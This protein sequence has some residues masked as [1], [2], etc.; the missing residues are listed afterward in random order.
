MSSRSGGTMRHTKNVKE[1]RPVP[2]WTI[3]AAVAIAHLAIALPALNPA[4]HNGGD[5]AGYIS[6]AHSLAT[7]ESYVEAW[8]PAELPH[9][10]YPPFYPALLA[11]AMLLG[12][13]AW[14]T[15]KLL[16]VLLIT[17]AVVLSFG[18]VRDRHGSGL[19]TGV[20]AILA[21]S[22]AL[23]WSSNWILSDPLFLALTLGCL[24]AFHRSDDVESASRTGH[25]PPNADPAG[26]G[27]GAGDRVGDRPG[28]RVGGRAGGR[29]G[30]WI[31]AGCLMA[32]LAT[33]TRT[34]GLPLILAVAGA[35]ALARRWKAVAGFGA[36]F[37]IPSLAWWLRSR[38]SGQAQYI[39]E[40]WLID[41]YRPDLGTAGVAD[42]LHRVLDNLEGYVFTHIPGGLTTWSGAPL[43]WLGVFLIGTGVVGWTMR[44]RDRPTVAE[45]FFPLYCGLILLW[46][47]V[48]SGDRFALPLYP[49]LLFYSGEALL[50]GAARVHPRVPLVGGLIVASLLLV[51]SARGWNDATR[52]AA[53]CREAVRTAGP[54]AC[55]SE[56]FQQFVAAARWLGENAP[57]G[58]GVFSRKP[59][60]FYTLS[61]V[62]SRTYP[63]SPDP[64]RFFDEAR[65]AG[66]SY[67]VLDRVDRLAYA[68]VTPVLMARPKA[69]CGL[70]GVGRGEATTQIFGIIEEEGAAA[71]ADG[72]EEEGRDVSIGPCPD[73]MRRAEP[74]DLPSYT[75]SRLPLLALPSP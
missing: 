39:S 61:G 66:V 75:T 73:A 71:E 3:L 47:A 7:G 18:W 23:L 63:L 9:T 20:A 34:A 72:A 16:S 37:A 46:P 35:L 32:I 27:E 48:W 68:Y 44:V 40:F 70:V 55:Y 42:L 57:E 60:I 5:N 17:T 49:L 43:T 11:G 25:Q 62:R 41:P 67:V 24:W 38:S 52:R 1:R 19:A 4:P 50:A 36:A 58:A 13:E 22:P 6:L 51:P 15:F 10:K 53:A 30:V 74:R 28:D 59:R 21:L 12:A 29:V 31:A 26:E 33:F 14:L 45:L 69:F 8:D 65:A 64:D 54:F 56:G 2:A